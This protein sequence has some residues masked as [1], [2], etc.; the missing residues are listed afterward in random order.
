VNA[1]KH[2]RPFRKV[3]FGILSLAGAL[4]IARWGGPLGLSAAGWNQPSQTD[5]NVTL[6]SWRGVISPSTHADG[7]PKS[8][9]MSGRLG[10][11]LDPGVTQPL[12]LTFV[13]PNPV[14]IALRAL[15]VNIDHLDRAHAGKCPVSTNFVVIQFRGNTQR[16]Q[17]PANGRT[18][19]NALRIP[20]SDW[21]KIGM[22]NAN[23]KQNGCLG[24]RLFVSLSGV[25]DDLTLKG[26]QRSKT[27]R[28]RPW[29]DFH[30]LD[31]GH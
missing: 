14:P 23:F 22:L 12:R 3:G 2:R 27:G 15:R 5:V 26:D 10:G 6:T 28:N 31:G 7:A 18:S 25:A 11:D 4:V 16:I 29:R 21:P 19:L 17:V 13:N 8:F 30:M 1:E 24:A 9:S 20:S